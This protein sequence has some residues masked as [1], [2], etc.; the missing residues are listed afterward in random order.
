[1]IAYVRGQFQK[2]KLRTVVEEF[3]YGSYEI[4]NMQLRAGGFTFRP[5]AFLTPTDFARLKAAPGRHFD[6][7]ITGLQVR[8]KSANV[9]GEVV[10]HSGAQ[11]EII[12]AAT[13]VTYRRA[14]RIQ[15]NALLR[16]RV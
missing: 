16:M 10:G 2:M 12:V 5:V 3:E 1:M 15:P 4:E 14:P 7:T 9:T 11:R 6:L 13:S 8:R